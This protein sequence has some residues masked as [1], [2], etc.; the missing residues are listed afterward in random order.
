MNAQTQL[1]NLRR[2]IE[3]GNDWKT[4]HP[5]SPRLDVEVNKDLFAPETVQQYDRN[6]KSVIERFQPDTQNGLTMADV[7][8]DWES[9]PIH[10]HFVQP[11][12]KWG[13]KEDVHTILDRLEI[14]AGSHATIIG[15]YTGE[16][17]D[18][19]RDYPLD[20]L[21][22]DPIEGWCDQAAERGFET[23]CIRADQLSSE[24]LRS[25]DLVVSFEAFQPLQETGA[26]YA[27]SRSCSVTYGHLIFESEWTRNNMDSDVTL[28]S[29][30][31]WL[32]NYGGSTSYRQSSGLRAYW[33]NAG[34]TAKSEQLNAPI[35]AYWTAMTVGDS[36]P[37]DSGSATVNITPDL[38]VETANTLH[39]TPKEVYTELRRCEAIMFERA[40]GTTVERFAPRKTISSACGSLDISSNNTRERER[41]PTWG[42]S[43]YPE[44]FD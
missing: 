22:T 8:D 37:D 25:T 3:A 35:V 34:G 28:L 17:A 30:F 4:Y 10:R 11:Q 21:F 2:Y 9:H 39:S 36:N 41:P 6:P 18:A 15:G 42:D 7:I 16:F 19:I 40:K 44:Q 26:T 1:N 27:L 23:E 29:N 12:G 13:T 43:E 24:Q 32:D 20:V 33:F 31:S 14:P 5:P 38:L